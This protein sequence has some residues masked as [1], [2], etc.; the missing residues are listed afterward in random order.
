MCIKWP[1]FAAGPERSV[2]TLMSSGYE[3]E[4]MSLGNVPLRGSGCEQVSLT[5]KS[6]Q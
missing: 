2:A 6:V 5:R 4:K 1:G 3:Y